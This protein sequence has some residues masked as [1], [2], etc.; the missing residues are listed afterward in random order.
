VGDISRV[1]QVAGKATHWDF[2]GLGTSAQTYAD[3]YNLALH[4][5]FESA[6]D[7]T[8]K[9]KAV[10][11]YKSPDPVIPAVGGALISIGASQ[12]Q[13]SL[14]STIVFVLLGLATFGVAHYDL[15]V[16]GE[17]SP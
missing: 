6:P 4:H 11:V 7:G 3:E 16:V 2:F 5:A 15:V 13:T 12:Y 10:K 1:E 14:P 8:A 17:P 9:I